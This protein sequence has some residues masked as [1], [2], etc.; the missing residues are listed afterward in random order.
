MHIFLSFK[1][2][3]RR[4]K[5]VLRICASLYRPGIDSKDIF[6]PFFSQNSEPFDHL[7]LPMSLFC[8]II[9]QR[10]PFHIKAAPCLPEMTP[11]IY[12]IKQHPS[13]IF[14]PTH[15]PS[16]LLIQKPFIR[17][18]SRTPRRTPQDFIGPTHCGDQGSR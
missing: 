16:D 8:I 17:S 1:L 3:S 4:F 2:V 11:L 15:L 14:S 10:S 9:C 13:I 7:M 18:P 12:S 6:P 5:L